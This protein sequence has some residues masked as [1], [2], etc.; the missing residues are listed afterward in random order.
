MRRVVRDTAHGHPGHRGFAAFQHF[1]KFGDGYPAL[2]SRN[3]DWDFWGCEE[4]R[5][6]F[7]HCLI[8]E[9]GLEWVENND[10]FLAQDGHGRPGICRIDG[11]DPVL[12]LVEEK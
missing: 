11:V 5:E 7:A 1:F 3:Q 6:M 4:R 10:L 12:E 8:T 2:E 9:H